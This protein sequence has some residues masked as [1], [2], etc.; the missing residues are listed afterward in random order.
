MAKRIRDVLIFVLALAAAFGL[1]YLS[2]LAFSLSF[3]NPNPPYWTSF[4]GYLRWSSIL[5]PPV[6][7]GLAFAR[8]TAVFGA[9][10]GALVIGKMA[11]A[12]WA[13]ILTS[14]GNLPRLGVVPEFAFAG[15]VYILL[16]ACV[17]ALTGWLRFKWFPRSPF[18]AVK[19]R[20][21]LVFLAF[22]VIG[23]GVFIKGLHGLYVEH[24]LKAEGVT[25]T[26][27]R[28]E[29]LDGDV[30][31]V[32][33][34]YENGE[35][36]LWDMEVPAGVRDRFNRGEKVSMRYLPDS[37]YRWAGEDSRSGLFASAGLLSI[38]LGMLFWR[39]VPRSK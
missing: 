19:L 37:D 33:F 35:E 20:F 5:G 15:L 27:Q 6:I 24:R 38:G 28:M 13:D 26:M 29:K 30:D 21:V 12:N 14:E 2:Q 36:L 25:V 39:R 3:E 4:E 17:A 16:C 22:V 32:Y 31:T 34:Q 7:I 18:A 8:R 10:I 23:G 11:W 9:S 1:S